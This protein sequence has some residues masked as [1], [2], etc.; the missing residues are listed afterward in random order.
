[1]S[2]DTAIT[3]V[4]TTRSLAALER[5]IERGIKTFQEV[6][7]A[8]ME[9]RDRSLYIVEFVSF[10]E[11]CLERWGFA[12]AR[13]RQLI[14][15]A[16][17]AQTVEISTVLNEGQAKALGQVSAENRQAVYDAA[18]KV[19]GG[20]PTAK[21]IQ[22]AA[23][24][25]E[26]YD[27]PKKDP[28]EKLKWLAASHRIRDAVWRIMER[29]EEPALLTTPA[30]LRTAAEQIESGQWGFDFQGEMAKYETKMRESSV[31]TILPS[32]ITCPNCSGTK[33]DDDGDCLQCR[34]PAV[35]SAKSMIVQD[36]PEDISPPSKSHIQELAKFRKFIDET[37]PKY[38]RLCL[39]S[40][41]DIAEVLHAVAKVWKTRHGADA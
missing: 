35:V 20:M 34:E 36:E 9:I 25:I 32:A 14:S 22:E 7:E 38:K 1:M 17:V 27:K 12:S 10:E 5:V 19:T 4:A 8:L 13:A 18:V 33:F 40:D 15:A 24:E 39:L 26:G 41:Y 29:M 2:T 37:I 21:A 16:K 6:G 30:V 11:Y 31:E 28:E 3:A 23:R